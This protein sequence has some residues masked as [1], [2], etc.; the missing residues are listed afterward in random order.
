MLPVGQPG[1]DAAEETAD[2]GGDEVREGGADC[3]GD[4]IG[5]LGGTAGQHAY[6]DGGV[7]VAAGLVGDEDAGEDRQAPA[8][9][10]EQPAAAVALGLAQHDVGDDATAQQGQHRRAGD[11]VQENSCHMS[12]SMSGSATLRNRRASVARRLWPAGNYNVVLRGWRS[13]GLVWC[14]APVSGPV[15]P[16][17]T[18][19]RTYRAVRARACMVGLRA[20]RAVAA[21]RPDARTGSMPGP[22][23][24]RRRP[25]PRTA[26]GAG[27]SIQVRA[28]RSGWAPP[29]R[30]EEHT[31]ALQ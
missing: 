19:A 11:L 25:P 9:V 31:S 18:A 23:R 2:R 5:V 13:A 24:S 8:E 20:V 21:T 1:P 17:R 4:A 28:L 22:P 10:D 16:V 6:G 30:S 27:Q 12:S 3:H 15:G 26:P 29:G 14:R 7:D